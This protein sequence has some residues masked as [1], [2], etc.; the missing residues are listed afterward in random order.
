MQLILHVANVVCDKKNCLYPNRVEVTDAKS[1]QEAVRFDHVCAEY[2]KAYR[3]KS[4]FIRSNVLVMDCDNDHT[5]DPNEWITEESL[6]E[7]IPDVSYAIAYSRNHMKEKEGRAAR[8]KFHVYFEIEETSDPDYYAAL[9]EAVQARF[10]FFDGNALDAA[11]FLF[12]ADAGECVWHEGWINIDEEVMVDASYRKEVDPVSYSG[13]IT[14]GNR[15]NTMSHFAG[16]VLK[17]YGI[18]DTARNAFLEN[19]KRCDPPLEAEELEAIWNSALRFYRKTVMSEPG[20]IP[21]DEY[22]AEFE[23]LKPDDFSDIG[24]ARALV[25]EYKGE[26]LYT[27][28][29]EYLSF[30]GVCWRENR[31]KAVG[32]V[33]EFL[34]MQL[35]EAGSLLATSSQMLIDSGIPEQVVRSGGKT[36]EKLIESDQMEAYKDYLAAKAYYAFVIKYRNFKNIVNTQSAAKPMVAVDINDF[37]AQE[38]FLNTPDA[39]FDLDKGLDGAMPHNPDDLITKVTNASPGEDGVKLWEDALDLFFCGDKELIDYVQETVGLAAI[40]KV[41]EE[42][43]IIAYGEGRNGKSTFWNTISR[44]LGSYSGSISADTLMAGN[45]KNVMN[46]IAEL[47]GKRLV[48]AS[49]LEE[50]MRL[51]TS[52]LKRLCSTDLVRGEKKFRDPFDFIPTH[53][54]VLYTNHLPKVGASDEGTWRRL[55]VIPFQAK[56][57]GSSDIKNYSDHLFEYAAPAII[58]WFIEGARRVTAH[59]HKTTKP[60]VVTDAI[61]AYRGMNDWMSHFLD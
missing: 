46:E 29:T 27:E 59:N 32:A 25:K 61:A 60:K 7:M 44:V 18:S 1:L 36:L 9:K 47:K 11:R 28:A 3:S 45:K 40:G 33:E 24:E 21:P 54:V 2:K 8:P 35:S 34:D 41:Y 17:K 48:I 56:I 12:G 55:I 4:N 13:P 20:Y 42:A 19:A 5:E 16:R 51:S 23:S 38:N 6:D 53:T 50:G 43:L 26:L 39:T 57:V 58:S 22:N 15:N 10:P 37:D 52:I 14:E 49:E 30:D 31:Q